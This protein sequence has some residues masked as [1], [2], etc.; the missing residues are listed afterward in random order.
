[1]AEELTTAAKTI[2]STE[3]EDIKLDNSIKRLIAEPQFLARII[4]RCVNECADMSIDE[5][6]KI[7]G[8][9]KVMEE[10]VEPGLTNTIN[11]T[12]LSQENYISGEELIKFDILTHI[13]VP[14]ENGTCIKIYLNI[15]A[16]K[17][18][19]PGYDI[20]ER[21]IFYLC[22]QLSSQC[23]VEFSLSKDDKIKYKNI[24]K[25]YSIWI[26]PETAAKRAGTIETIKLEKT[27][28]K[29]GKIID[30]S[31]I[32][33]RYDIM[34]LKIIRLAKNHKYDLDDEELIKFLTDLVNDEMSKSEKLN[35]LFGYGVK[36]TK[37]VESEVGIMTSY[38]TS[39]AQ[40]NLIKGRTEERNLM[41]KAFAA[42]K[43]GKTKEELLAE[44]FD[45]GTIDTALMFL[46]D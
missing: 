14:L 1:M 2:A 28:T 8:K 29:N 40:K 3:P 16:Q 5:I 41:Q 33:D 38:A 20:S 27:V 26:C 21:G 30:S 44:G 42:L 19:K 25:V 31:T 7:I 10:F 4:K 6:I 17:N 18:E 32:P 15:E 34:E 13:F 35:A 36:L 22:R 12:E 23:G 11:A 37:T 43:E 39:I 9:V 46:R 24:K 45:E